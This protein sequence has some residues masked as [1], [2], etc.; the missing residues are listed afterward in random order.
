MGS[1]TKTEAKPKR[2]TLTPAE[3]IAKA[4]AELAAAKEKAYSKLVKE[5]ASLLEQEA[6]NNVKI[7]ELQAK[8]FGI[9]T[10][11]GEIEDQVPADLLPTS[12]TPLPLE[13]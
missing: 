2:V 11:L 8:N 4:E 13:S 1:N 12:D 9:S 7:A 3:R 10:R 6:K 5:H